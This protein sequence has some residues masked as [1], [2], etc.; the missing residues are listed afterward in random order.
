MEPGLFPREALFFSPQ[1]VKAVTA[2][3]IL[4]PCVEGRKAKVP[5]FGQYWLILLLWF[6]QQQQKPTKK[7]K[8]KLAKLSKRG[9][10]LV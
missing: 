1:R 9:L 7:P 2:G 5:L 4:R 10:V 8:N 6:K 3:R